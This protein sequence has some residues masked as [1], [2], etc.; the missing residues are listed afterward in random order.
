M[1]DSEKL[2]KFIKHVVKVSKKTQSKIKAKENLGKHID[3]IKTLAVKKGVKKTAL[4][5]ALKELEKKIAEV[6]EKEKESL[7]LQKKDLSKTDSISD[8]L[9]SMEQRFSSFTTKDIQ[10]INSLKQKMERVESQRDEQID[11]AVEELKLKLNE[12]QANKTDRTEKILELEKKIKEKVS[13]N[14]IEL[15][16]IE[17]QLEQMELK[18][19]QMKQ[20]GKHNRKTLSNFKEKIKGLKYNLF[21][22]KQKLMQEE[23]RKGAPLPQRPKIPK[24]SKKQIKREIPKGMIRHE[25]KLEPI[26]EAPKLQHESFEDVLSEEHI[27]VIRLRRE[28]RKK[29]FLKRLFG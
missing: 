20:E 14:F 18:Y 21:V 26:P 28:K 25:L 4:T 23:M 11:K 5:R 1:E 16:K 2:R 7:A 8:D 29:S 10:L 3:K 17:N 6:I 22:R 24:F 13:D 27:P 12:M 9:K 19:R 15:M